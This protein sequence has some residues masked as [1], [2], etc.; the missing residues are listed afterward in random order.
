[1][2]QQISV[3]RARELVDAYSR[4]FHGMTR[5]VT[6]ELGPLLQALERYRD[7]QQTP[8]NFVRVYFG[9]ATEEEDPADP[10]SPMVEKLTVFF[11][12]AEGTD[13]R[14]NV[15]DIDPGTSNLDME[16]FNIGTVCP[17]PTCTGVSLYY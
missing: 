7:N 14:V 16:P 6:F 3:E 17:P 9:L 4:V 10:N 12:P 13:P 1:M 8:A 11:Q 5:S 2:S 15:N